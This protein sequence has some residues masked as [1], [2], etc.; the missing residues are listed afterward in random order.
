LYIL[1]RPLA[2][3]QPQQSGRNPGHTQQLPRRRV[4]PRVLSLPYQIRFL[5]AMHPAL[6]GQV[7]GPVYRV[8]A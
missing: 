8:I 4:R 3:I 7:L 1:L 6:I 2:A 5:L